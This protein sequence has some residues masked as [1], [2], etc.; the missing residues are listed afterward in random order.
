MRR[1][2]LIDLRRFRVDRVARPVWVCR[3]PPRL[4]W[5]MAESLRWPIRENRE[6]AS[7]VGFLFRQGL[8]RRRW[9]EAAGDFFAVFVAGFFGAGLALA[10]VLR[11]FFLGVG[12][13][14]AGADLVRLAAF[15]AGT[16]GGGGAEMGGAISMPKTSLRSSLATVGAVT[17]LVPRVLAWTTWVSRSGSRRRSGRP[18]ARA[19]WVLPGRRPG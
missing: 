7:N 15:W 2:Y 12:R 3:W 10:V 8:G 17:E 6:P 4:R 19:G 5:F 11:V 18:E 16:T 9:T 13:G 14:V 1:N